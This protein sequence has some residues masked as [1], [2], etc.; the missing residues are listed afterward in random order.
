[1]KFRG[2]AM[3]LY[4]HIRSQPDRIHWRQDHFPA[5]LTKDTKKFKIA[6]E[7]ICYVWPV[8]GDDTRCCYTLKD[9]PQRPPRIPLKLDD[10]LKE[11]SERYHM[12]TRAEILVC[13]AV[14][15]GHCAVG[16]ETKAFIRQLWKRLYLQKAIP[17]SQS[18][19]APITL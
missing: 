18:T 15:M 16:A 6:I 19:A 2:L 9:F 10:V 14:T 4:K 3:Q 13:E 12:L 8:D 1:M 17:Q 5:D 11:I 7:K